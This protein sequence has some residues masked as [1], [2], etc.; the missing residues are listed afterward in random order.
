MSL[1]IISAQR[2]CAINIYANARRW[3]IE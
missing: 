3:R 1:F 2:Q